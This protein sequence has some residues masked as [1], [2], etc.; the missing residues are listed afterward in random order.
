MTQVIKSL[1]LL[2]WCFYER[3]GSAPSFSYV[4]DLEIN[5]FV[6]RGGDS[7]SEGQKSWNKLLRDYG[8]GYSDELDRLIADY[9]E[10]GYFDERLGAEL[11]ERNAANVIEA[12][13]NL[14]RQAWD[15]FVNSFADNESEFVDSLVDSFKGGMAYLSLPELNQVVVVLRQLERGEAATN[16]V[17]EYVALHGSELVDR[18]ADWWPVTRERDAY[19]LY[20]IN[21]LAE[22][23]PD[24]GTVG[25]VVKRVVS[26]NSWSGED[27]KFLAEAT[28]DQ[29]YEFFRSESSTDL[30]AYVRRCLEFGQYDNASEHGRR[31]AQATRSALARLASESRINRLRVSVLYDVNADTDNE[32]ESSPEEAGS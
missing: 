15:L 17:D 6:D 14:Y 10:R 3:D 11:Q 18:L 24:G 31:I 27:E 1:V 26:S 7:I 4:K 13:R 22:A 2:A 19:L 25:E 32:G 8:Y 21:R 29:Y 23:V 20:K 5:F 30:R 9:V 12:R 28:V 16:L